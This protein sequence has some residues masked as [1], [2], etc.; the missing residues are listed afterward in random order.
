MDP[1]GGLAR[2]PGN[3]YDVDEVRKPYRD[4]RTLLSCPLW[5]VGVARTAPGHVWLGSCRL[6]STGQFAV[7]PR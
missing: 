4:R 7:I 5:S 1:K 3:A 6:C 2:V